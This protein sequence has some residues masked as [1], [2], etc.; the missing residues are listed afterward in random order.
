MLP[1]D[2]SPLPYALHCPVD[3]DI[4]E[5]QE[6][7]ALYQGRRYYMD[8]KACQKAFLADPERYAKEI[9]PRAALFASPRPDRVSYGPSFLYLG[10]YVVMGLFFGALASYIAI[11]KGLEG[12]NWFVGGFLLNI[13]AIVFLVTRPSKEMLFRSEG[14]SKTPRTYEPDACPNCGKLN[15]PSANRCS[16]C[17]QALEARVES[18]VTRAS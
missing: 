17:E 5:S 3:N 10:I 11:Q 15:H 4:A 7:G 16:R 14:V 2:P 18:E 13:I 1:P 8:R 9:E 12:K 6:F